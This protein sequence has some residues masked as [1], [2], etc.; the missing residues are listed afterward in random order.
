MHKTH[1]HVISAALPL[2]L[3]ITISS[4]CFSPDVDAITAKMR[5]ECSIAPDGPECA[6]AAQ[7]VEGGAT[8]GPAR[9]VYEHFIRR[10]V[11]RPETEACLL[12]ISCT[13]DEAFDTK[14]A[15][16]AECLAGDGGGSEIVSLPR[17]RA[18]CDDELRAC[19][20]EG[21][22]TA[23]DVDACFATWDACRSALSCP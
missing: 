4:G 21:G 18:R 15:A 19:G 3:A 2:T 22:C 17:C 20:G 1:R 7:S 16:F 6:W 12:E 9:R 5:D 23:A 11:T 14:F 8:D 13:E 10:N